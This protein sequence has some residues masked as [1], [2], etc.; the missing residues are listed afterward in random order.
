VTGPIPK[1]LL[2]PE[3]AADVLSIGRTRVYRLIATGELRSMLIGRSRRIPSSALVEF[4]RQ[5]EAGACSAT[6]TGVGD[7]GTD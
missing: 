2:S 7:D 3:E 1:L 5:L 6:V 4:V